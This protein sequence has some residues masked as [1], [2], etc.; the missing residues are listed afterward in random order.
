MLTENH[1][2]YYKPMQDAATEKSVD[3]ASVNPMELLFS[4][5]RAVKVSARC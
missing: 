4:A 3:V 5:E 2:V 1:T